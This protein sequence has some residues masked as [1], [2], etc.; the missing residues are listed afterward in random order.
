MASKMMAAATAMRADVDCVD[1]PSMNR[2]KGHRPRKSNR[3]AQRRR[4]GR[5]WR[6]QRRVRGASGSQTST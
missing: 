6:G 2:R 1:S 3:P 4:R 5:G